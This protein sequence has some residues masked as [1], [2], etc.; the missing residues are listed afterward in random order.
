M[1]ARSS[2]GQQIDP[3]AGRGS[4]WRALPAW[5]V[6]FGGIV[7]AL[8]VLSAFLVI[9]FTRDLVR[10]NAAERLRETAAILAE[11]THQHFLSTDIDLS[12]LQERLEKVAVSNAALTSYLSQDAFNESLRDMAVRLPEVN[13][14]FVAGAEG[15]LLASSSGPSAIEID[16]SDREYFRVLRD[17]DTVTAFL[18]RPEMGRITNLQTVFLVRRINGPENEFRGVVG[19]AF[20]LGYF[21][22]YISRIFGAHPDLSFLLLRRDGVLLSSIPDGSRL[23]DSD[24]EEWQFVSKVLASSEG[25]VAIVESSLTRTERSLVAFQSV[26]G[27][28]LVLYTAMTEK[29]A[30]APLSRLTIWTAVSAAVVIG[31]AACVVM[32]I[33]R[34]AT[35]QRLV[36]EVENQAAEQRFAKAFYDSPIPL[37]ILTVEGYVIEA[38]RA[39]CELVGYPREALTGQSMLDLGIVS[40]KVREEAVSAVE[41]GGGACRDIPITLTAKDGERRQVK[42]SAAPIILGGVA[43]RL[44]TLVDETVQKRVEEQLRQSQRMEAVGQLTGGVAHDFNNLLGVISGNL[45]LLAE[46]FPDRPRAQKMLQTAIRATDRGANLTRSLLAFA[47]RQPL[48]PK[49]LD[50]NELVR[51][52]TELLR[53]TVPESID[54]KFIAASTWSCEVDPGQLQNAILNLAANARDAMPEGGCLTI[55]TGDARLD[56]TYAARHAD[57][58]VGDYVMLAVSDT[59]KG[60]SRDVA[61]RAFEPFF[62]TKEVGK[63]T[64]LGLS[65]VY[66]FAKQSGGHISMYS[67]VGEGTTVRVYLP[68][69]LTGKERPAVRTD[70]G[71]AKGQGETVLIVEDDP[72]MRAL[73][74]TMVRTL[75]YGVFEAGNAAEA[76]ALLR[77][78]RGGLLLLTDVV[79]PGSMNGPTLAL[80]AARLNPG[81][82][83]LY[84]SGYTENAILHGGRLDPGVRL[85]QKP[86]RR[87]E[88]AAMIRAA[89]DDRGLS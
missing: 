16:V 61:A 79:L 67:E 28:P 83:V 35:M 86:F 27:Y 50:A 65:M 78:E 32:L 8:F 37:V 54:I 77:E 40:A 1:N 49:T 10:G 22:H 24:S 38:N 30:V 26:R 42:A 73:T 56:D 69:S 15:R 81:I 88:L 68:R 34:H 9:D 2:A 59:G 71:N 29:A 17:G 76:L 63:G 39:Y 7:A 51:D 14:F 3:P 66:G 48:A 5:T 6:L 80:E 13:A 11:Q 12:D 60:M 31:L 21:S 62:T 44:W 33:V 74:V 18:S 87:H 57:V 41:R 19:A 20:S 75:G 47:R 23:I 70:I 36:L 72:D 89:L 46:E 58:K 82:K 84:M 4:S 53:R 55:E 52:M 85:L 43:H 64:G 45:E 25:S